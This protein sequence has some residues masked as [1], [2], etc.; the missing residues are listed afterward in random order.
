MNKLTLFFSILDVEG[1]DTCRVADSC[2]VVVVIARPGA[3]GVA[4]CLHLAISSFDST[5][6]RCRAQEVGHEELGRMKAKEI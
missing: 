2:E 5:D 4:T 6:P 3:F 1:S